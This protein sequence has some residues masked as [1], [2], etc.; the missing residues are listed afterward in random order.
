[1]LYISGKIDEAELY[2]KNVI[3]YDPKSVDA[4]VGLGNIYFT[5]RN[6]EISEYYYRD[7][8]AADPNSFKAHFLLGKLLAETHRLKSSIEAFETA[9]RLDPGNPEAEYRLGV[10]FD[11]LGMRDRAN[12]HYKRVLEKE[13]KHW[14]A[15]NNLCWNM[16]TAPRKNKHDLAEAVRLG[17]L[18]CKLTNYKH[19]VLL[20]SLA[21]AYAAVG[22]YEDAVKTSKMALR[23]IKN[24]E[25]ESA[26]VEIKKHLQLFE[27]G[28]PC[29]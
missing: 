19:Y 25:D 3:E 12:L 26:F 28:K 13:P 1:M 18:G 6:Y 22:R 29:M 7:A 27:S 10:A 17:E 16:A 24:A 23:L 8:I 2:F 14:N 11:D 21:A 9:L 15:I 4:L 5:K 20:D